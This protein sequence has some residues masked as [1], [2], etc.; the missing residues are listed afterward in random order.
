M[1]ANKSL[2]NPH[3]LKH[4][5]LFIATLLCQHLFYNKEGHCADNSNYTSS[6]VE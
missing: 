3:I 1:Q 2:A 4:K 5:F 6:A